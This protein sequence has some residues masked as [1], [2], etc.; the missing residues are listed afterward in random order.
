MDCMGQWKRW[1]RPG[2]IAIYFILAIIALPLCIIELHREGAPTHVQAWFAGGIFVMC[3]VPISLWGILQHLVN[4]TQ[5]HLQRHII[6]ILWMVP[7]Y[8]LNAWFALRFPDA[9]IYLD[10]VRECYEAYVIYNFMAYLLSSL[11][12]EHPQ[13]DLVLRDKEQVRHLFPICWLRPW[14]MTGKLIDRCKH[15]ALQYTV[16]RPVTTVIAL[17]CESFN[18]Y[19]EGQFNFTSAWSYLVIINNIS[20]IWAMY[21]L[22][23][24]Y[25]AMKEE[26]A[27]I[28]PIPKFLC[29]KFVVFFSF[30]QSVIIA[31]LVELNAIPS[32]GE[33]IYYKN[34]DQAAAGLQDFC[35]CVEMF[36]AAIAHYYSFS[37][38][39]FVD[40]NFEGQS[41][42]QSFR[43]MWDVSDMKDDV[44]EHVRVIGNKVKKTVSKPLLR[45]RS[46]RTPLLTES[47][48]S[49]TQ[50]STSSMNN[51]PTDWDTASLETASSLRPAFNATDSMNNY[52]VFGSSSEHLEAAPK[53]GEQDGQE[54]FKGHKVEVHRSSNYI[55][56]TSDNL[57]VSKNT[58][59]TDLMLVDDSQ[60][61]A[62]NINK[63]Q[64]TQTDI[65]ADQ[66]QDTQTDM[67][68]DQSQ[69]TKTDMSANQSQ[70]TKTDMSADQAGNSVLK[71]G[72]STKESEEKLSDNLVEEQE[73]YDNNSLT[74]N[75]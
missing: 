17:I 60:T 40:S 29:V 2:F 47:K 58:E 59:N 46:E 6:R 55:S 23:L 66:S 32:N 39:P 50:G 7:I 15:G 74:V 37:H 25:K 5:P 56:V 9:A 21:C 41:W 64:D 43:S 72:I 38:K 22:V 26:L 62:A 57:A 75:A 48:D 1:I 70:D 18:K 65:S 42:W 44:V 14:P 73:N 8:A 36:L 4:Y 20:Q 71:P 63:K 28:K 34:V 53:A 68:A 61:T 11:W 24:F 54:E 67:S 12:E 33:W 30:W 10:T 3:A 16:I 31:A 27:P 49:Y 35:I 19:D 51:D 13:L 52:I 45:D 69:D